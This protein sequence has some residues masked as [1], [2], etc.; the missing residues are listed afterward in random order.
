MLKSAGIVDTIQVLNINLGNAF[1]SAFGA[2]LGATFVQKI[3]RRPMLV[4]VCIACS[5]LFACISIGTGLYATKHIDS[6]GTAGIVFIFFFGIVYSF[7]W[8]PLQALYP[9][10]C[11]SYEQRAKGMALS[12]AGV[13]AAVLLNQFAWPVALQHI[14]WYTYLIFVGWDLVQAAVCYW[15]AVETNGRTLEELS[16]IYAA[17]NPR[18]ASTLKKEVV[19]SNTN[20]EIVEVKGVV[21]EPVEMRS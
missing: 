15:L 6:A 8:T 21:G 19:V 10:E 11:L 16:E 3:G 5:I 14:G 12:S 13:N 4:G 2:Y 1:T 20:A 17:K 18:K 9:V 7:G